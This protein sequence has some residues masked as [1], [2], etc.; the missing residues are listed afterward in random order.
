M[1][2]VTFQSNRPKDSGICHVGVKC[3]QKKLP[4][5]MQN[6]P[7]YRF[8]ASHWS[9]SFDIPAIYYLMWLLW[10]LSK[11][12]SSSR[13]VLSLLDSGL[14]LKEGRCAGNFVAYF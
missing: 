11:K 13:V 2:M 9:G 10:M 8:E 7:E 6:K 12:C 5:M 1:N 4:P 3:L 14:K